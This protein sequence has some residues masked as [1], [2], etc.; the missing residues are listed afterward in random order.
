MFNTKNDVIKY[1][2]YN[3]DICNVSEWVIGDTC[4]W[5][6][7]MNINDNSRTVLYYI[8]NQNYYYFITKSCLNNLLS[9][10]NTQGISSDWDEYPSKPSRSD[11][12]Y[13]QLLTSEDVNINVVDV[14]NSVLLFDISDKILNSE[15]YKSR[16]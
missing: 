15:E 13:F 5:R 4:L 1:I 16:Q 10:K 2:H 3:L 7:R 12:E 8:D 11:D 9:K 14:K 6:L